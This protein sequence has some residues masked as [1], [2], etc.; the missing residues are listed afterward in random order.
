MILKN[1]WQKWKGIKEEKYPHRLLL[2]TKFDL[3]TPLVVSFY[4]LFGKIFY[5][6]NEKSI[7]VAML[8]SSIEGEG[9]SLI[10]VNLGTTLSV[11]G[12]KKVLLVDCDL[13]HP[14][15]HHIFKVERTKG[16]SELLS[17]DVKIEEA[18]KPTRIPDLFLMTAGKIHLTTS[19]LIG[20]NI[21]K[22]I[23]KEL[24]ET[25]DLIL[26]DSSPVNLTQIPTI[27][28]PL[29]DGVIFVIQAERTQRETIKYAF[30]S[31]KNSKANILGSIFNMR[32]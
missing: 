32:Y 29:M 18:I 11:L 19:M 8:T 6:F 14:E 4:N 21:F 15:L 12:K 16:I 13:H 9:K 20:S 5:M 2:D 26:F 28:A 7:Q 30:E 31:L 1:I 24:K 25:Y 23:L 10:T 17:G 22:N 3:K 27:L